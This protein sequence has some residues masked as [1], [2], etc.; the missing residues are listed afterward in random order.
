MAIDAITDEELA[1]YVAMSDDEGATPTRSSSPSSCEGKA[2]LVKRPWTPEEDDALVAAVR[3]YGACRWSMIAT[4]LSTGRV[5]KQ[6]RERWN[7]HLCPHVKKSEWSEE[8]DRAILEGVAVLGTRWCE[9][10]KASA[11]QGRTDNAIKNRFYSLQR[12]MR[13]RQLNKVPLSP[14]ACGKRS[15]GDGGDFLAPGQRERIV[16]VATELAF[17]TDEQ[18]RDRLIA[19]LTGALQEGIAP[20][21]DQ[22]SDLGTL[23]SPEMAAEMRE[24]LSQLRFDRTESSSTADVD[25]AHRSSADPVQLVKLDE[26]LV[27]AARAVKLEQAMIGKLNNSGDAKEPQGTEA[28]E[29]V[30]AVVPALSAIRRAQPLEDI[31]TSRDIDSVGPPSS[32]TMTPASV[33][34][35]PSPQSV[36]STT[37]VS[38]LAVAPSST[39]SPTGSTLTPASAT[40]GMSERRFPSHE[41]ENVVS[42]SQMAQREHVAIGA[43]LGGRHAYKAL[44]SPLCI[45]HPDT[46]A[47]S[48]MKRMRTP[49]G[50]VRSSFEP[51]PSPMPAMAAGA[52]RAAE[53][54]TEEPGAPPATACPNIN[55]AQANG[56]SEPLITSPMAELLNLSLFKDLFSPDAP[57]STATRELP[58]WAAAPSPAPTCT[59]ATV[60]T[61]MPAI[62]AAVVASSITTAVE[63]DVDKAAVIAVGGQPTPGTTLVPTGGTDELAASQPTAGGASAVDG[64]AVPAP[65][66]SKGGNKSAPR[67]G[68]EEPT[69]Q[70]RPRRSARG[71]CGQLASAT[72]GVLVPAA[73]GC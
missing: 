62:A 39:S 7:N 45:P 27:D 28:S 31:D 22:A 32:T 26:S 24:S 51:Q 63:E 46:L 53:T 49:S 69:L 2:A 68:T 54:G 29:P 64:D 44:L 48:P 66:S 71:A 67:L 1:E 23:D 70:R 11:L 65:A 40:G 73:L 43:A 5:G 34:F 25:P 18:D 16:S 55:F 17:A 60:T 47:G 36:G 33:A 15:L 21:D 35:N 3:K 52:G 72:N 13:S 14:S 61:A 9:I 30:A 38:P 58:P 10:V 56:S 37:G 41:K 12:R 19:E 8:E 6:C 59:A 4:H 57:S 20:D 50:S 42:P